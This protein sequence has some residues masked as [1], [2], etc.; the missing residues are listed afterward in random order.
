MGKYQKKVK[1][2]HR[3]MKIRVIGKGG[4][5]FKSTPYENN[6]DYGR[7]KSAPAGFGA[8]EEKKED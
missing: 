3:K 6:P 5:K 7:S 2:K 4:N 1:K 8:L